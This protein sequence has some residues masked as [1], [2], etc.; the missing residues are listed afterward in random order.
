MVNYYPLS[1]N[2]ENKRCLVV[3]AGEVANRKVARLLDCGALV[4]VIAP[5]LT[6][7]LK[8][9]VEKKKITVK[10]RRVNLSDLS[11]AFLVISAT[12]DRKI[13]TLISA[14][15]RRKGILVNVVDAPNECNFILPSILKKGDLSIAIS[16]NGVS[17]A[18]AKKIRQELEQKFGVE[19]MKLLRML[20]AIRPEALRRIKDPQL[21]KAFFQKA[22]QAD[23]LKLL[24]QNKE[25]RARLKLKAILE[26]AAI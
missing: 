9:L 10:H 26:D 3:G 1:L 25:G 15:C 24:K 2:L 11:R 14:Y 7:G 21:R 17:P 18:L 22:I 4:T 23:M 20:K 5:E 16:T 12:S 19:Y 6:A 13:N 8:A